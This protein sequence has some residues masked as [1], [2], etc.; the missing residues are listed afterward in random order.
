MVA[1]AVVTKDLKIRIKIQNY[2]AKTRMSVNLVTVDLE[3]F[4]IPKEALLVV[5]LKVI[6][7]A[8]EIT[9]VVNVKN[10]DSNLDRNS[11]HV[12]I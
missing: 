12:K 4:L 9:N 3:L 11:S 8:K 5:A 7:E 6:Y 2:L 1:N 10:L